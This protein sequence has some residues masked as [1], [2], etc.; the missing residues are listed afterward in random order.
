MKY[1]AALGCI[2]Y[3]IIS[4]AQTDSLVL[5][6]NDVIVGEVKSMDRGVVVIETD[7]SDSDFKIEWEKIKRIKTSERYLIMLSDG[8]RVSGY[9]MS[10]PDGSIS[11]RDI[12]GGTYVV[13][14]EEIVYINNLDDGFLSRLYA[15]IDFGYSLTKANNQNQTTLNSRVG[16]IQDYWSVDFYYNALLS[17]QDSTPDIRRND[18]GAGFRYYLPSDWFLSADITFLANTEQAIDLRTNSKIG[19]GNYFIRSNHAY[20]GASVGAASIRERFAESSGAADRNSWEAFI[21]TELNLYDIG[22]LNLFTNVIVYPSIT[23]SGRLRTDFRFD[24][25]YD[26]LFLDDLYIRAGI[27]VNY[28]NQPAVAGNETDYVFTTGIGWKW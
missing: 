5:N 12:E 14:P 17:R 2:F 9:F 16:Y 27:T 7:Y 19:V 11:I 28:D 22:D 10:A 20:W 18:A 8:R 23:E 26:D 13:K 24:A 3:S 15:N 21:G 4:V 25:K 6:N 1:L